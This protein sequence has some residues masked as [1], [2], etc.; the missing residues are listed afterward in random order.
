LRICDQIWNVIVII[1]SFV[2]CVGLSIGWW[3]WYLSVSY[4]GLLLEDTF[5]FINWFLLSNFGLIFSKLIVR[6]YG[7]RFWNVDVDDAFFL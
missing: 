4:E 7:L 1:L 3:T 2:N 6:Q 5:L